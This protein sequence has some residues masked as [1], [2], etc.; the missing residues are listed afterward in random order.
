[1]TCPSDILTAQ[2]I[3][4]TKTG[5]EPCQASA[6]IS[7]IFVLW[8]ENEIK[9]LSKTATKRTSMLSGLDYQMKER[10]LSLDLLQMTEEMMKSTSTASS[11]LQIAQR[12]LRLLKKLKT[13]KLVRF[14]TYRPVF[15][16]LWTLLYSLRSQVLIT[17]THANASPLRC[18]CACQAEA[19]LT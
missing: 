7:G 4:K 11:S 12:E 6:D 14:I 13:L 18:A 10:C 1:M 17:L 19:N 9:T 16:L 8:K 5:F 15:Q 2:P 3:F